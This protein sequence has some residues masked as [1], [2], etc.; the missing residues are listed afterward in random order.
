MRNLNCIDSYQRNLSFA[1]CSRGVPRG[2][3]LESDSARFLPR[4]RIPL[5]GVQS[6]EAQATTKQSRVR[7]FLVE[8]ERVQDVAIVY[9]RLQ[10]SQIFFYLVCNF[11]SLLS[12][13]RFKDVGLNKRAL[14]YHA[15]IT[16]NANAVLMPIYFVIMLSLER[17]GIMLIIT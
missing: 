9:L 4:L 6:S 7:R 16:F 1:K 13:K 14:Q 10:A 8:R 12:V 2:D 11:F 3:R 15:E 5:L 17:R